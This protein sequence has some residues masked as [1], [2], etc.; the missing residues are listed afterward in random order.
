VVSLNVLSQNL[1]GGPEKTMKRLSQDSRS[2]GRD[3]NPEQSMN[4]RHFTERDFA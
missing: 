3:Y 1:S 2:M 4:Y